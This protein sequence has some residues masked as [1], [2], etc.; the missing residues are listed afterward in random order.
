M[1]YEHDVN[2]AINTCH[3]W[4]ER[5]RD[6]TLGILHHTINQLQEFFNQPQQTMVN[7]GFQV[8]I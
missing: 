4:V 5:A 6:H 7:N 1:L 8:Y 3:D 2:Y